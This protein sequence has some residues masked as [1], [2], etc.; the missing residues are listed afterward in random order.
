MESSLNLPSAL[1]PLL[2]HCYVVHLNH[3]PDSY[4]EEA[5]EL[6]GNFH[7]EI[8]LLDSPS[9]SSLAPAPGKVMLLPLKMGSSI[10]KESPW[11]VPS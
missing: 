5:V 3:K 7:L 9:L 6:S 8:P 1:H 11:V 2:L 4:T 10:S